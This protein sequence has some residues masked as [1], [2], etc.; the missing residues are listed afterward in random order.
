MA[1]QVP[2]HQADSVAM[3]ADARSKGPIEVTQ[4]P[5]WARANV[6]NNGDGTWTAIV[7]T[8]SKEETATGESREEALGKAA[9][10]VSVNLVENESQ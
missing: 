5:V 10:L 9:D 8:V 4:T 6:Q 1:E 7:Q 2:E 3:T